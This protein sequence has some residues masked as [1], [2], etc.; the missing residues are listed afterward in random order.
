MQRGQ[1]NGNH[2]A[3]APAQHV[4]GLAKLQCLDELKSVV[5]Q[6]RDGE[7][8]QGLQVLC[9]GSQVWVWVAGAVGGWVGRWVVRW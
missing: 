9:R 7:R 8:L 2:A 3:H 6:P 1:R 5:G 4:R